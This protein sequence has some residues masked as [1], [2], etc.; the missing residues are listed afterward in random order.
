MRI[1]DLPALCRRG[2]RSSFDTALCVRS[3][4]TRRKVGDGG[5]E[6]SLDSE[7]AAV[8]VKSCADGPPPTQLL[9]RG[10]GIMKA[11]TELGVGTSRGCGTRDSNTTV[12]TI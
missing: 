8:I 2:V 12:M 11:W 1:R 5:E 7:T 4:S 6:L 9:W 10:K 3:R